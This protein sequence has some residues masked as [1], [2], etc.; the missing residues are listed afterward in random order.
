MR[1]VL[2]L[3]IAVSLL[4][5][6]CTKEEYLAYSGFGKVPI[7]VA[8]SELDNI[9]SQDPQAIE[10]SGPIFLL[11]DFFFM[12]EAGKGIHVF[13]LTDVNQENSIT[14]INIPAVSDFTIDGN[15]L[16]ADSWKDLVSIDISDI[17]N[18]VF[19]SRTTDVFDPFLFPQL[20][21]GPFECVDP[22]RGAVIGWEDKNLENVLC[23][24]VN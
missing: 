14:F 3:S 2:S 18:V 6:S 4:L 8:F 5:S 13:D 22:D 10:R 12:V 20:F 15:I 23:H 9:R 11:G 19:L 7:Y 24:T 1:Y 21:V 16:F 17:H